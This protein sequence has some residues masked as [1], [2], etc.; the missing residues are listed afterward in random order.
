MTSMPSH[1]DHPAP[2]TAEVENM[3]LS[4]RQAAI[5]N[6]VIEDLSSAPDDVRAFAERASRRYLEMFP[7]D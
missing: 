2:R 4:D 7:A 3:S 6:G 5:S 1:S